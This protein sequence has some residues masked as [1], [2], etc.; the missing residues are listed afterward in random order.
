MSIWPC[1]I[2]GAP[3]VTDYLNTI[4]GTICEIEEHC[5]NGCTG[6]IFAYGAHWERIGDRTWEWA[7]TETPE[8]AG[9]RYE[10][11]QTA[12]EGLKAKRGK[13]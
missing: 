13:R 3:H 4:E 2:C 9:K 11:R 6:Y 8:E 5:P 10:E 12:I 7:Y 1:P